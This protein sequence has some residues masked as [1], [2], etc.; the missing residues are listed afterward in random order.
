MLD[1]EVLKEHLEYRFT[2]LYVSGM[3][4]SVATTLIDKGYEVDLEEPELDDL[5]TTLKVYLTGTSHIRLMV[6]H[7]VSTNQVDLMGAHYTQDGRKYILDKS[8]IDVNDIYS[9][10]MTGLSEV[11][12]CQ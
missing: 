12:P 10:I 7:Y 5:T 9:I 2:H 4:R 8:N 3:L 1:T 11:I 6:F